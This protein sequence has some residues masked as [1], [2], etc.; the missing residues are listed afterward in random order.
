[1]SHQR[2]E[3]QQVHSSARA[4]PRVPTADARLLAAPRSFL[5][6][7]PKLLISKLCPARLARACRPCTIAGSA[8]RH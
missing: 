8:H 6:Q 3:Q 7:A 1:M 4:S 5:E 2:G